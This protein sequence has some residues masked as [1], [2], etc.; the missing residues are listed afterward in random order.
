MENWHSIPGTIKGHICLGDTENFLLSMSY[1]LR[2]KLFSKHT[3]FGR[4]ENRKKCI[5]HLS[6]LWCRVLSVVAT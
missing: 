4:N 3:L 6:A 5:V 1:I 2:G